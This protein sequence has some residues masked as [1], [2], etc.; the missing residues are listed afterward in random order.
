MFNEDNRETFLNQSKQVR[1][2]STRSYKCSSNF[3]APLSLSEVAARFFEWASS[4]VRLFQFQTFDV[5]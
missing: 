5:L 1:R 2:R 4:P 3:V